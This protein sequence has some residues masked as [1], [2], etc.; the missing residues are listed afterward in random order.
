VRSVA[1]SKVIGTCVTMSMKPLMALAAAN[2][3]QNVCS[4]IGAIDATASK[5]AVRNQHYRDPA[6]RIRAAR[7]ICHAVQYPLLM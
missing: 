5:H 2:R 7:L 3:K 6:T 1:T 4:A